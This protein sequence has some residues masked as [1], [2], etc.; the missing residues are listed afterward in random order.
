MYRSRAILAALILGV[1][2]LAVDV[3]L[4][5]NVPLQLDSDLDQAIKDM[6]KTLIHVQET[7]RQV[8]DAYMVL[9]QTQPIRET[10]PDP[11]SGHLIEL[12]NQLAHLGRSQESSFTRLKES[13]DSV[14]RQMLALGAALAAGQALGNVRWEDIESRG[15]IV[16]PIEEFRQLKLGTP[17]Y[18]VIDRMGLPKK[19][20]GNFFETLRVV[21]DNP[22]G[23]ERPEISLTFGG[24][25]LVAKYIAD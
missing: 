7:Q 4:R 22:D 13:I 20:I 12:L 15:R 17:Y 8:L 25:L 23:S 24:G 6:H 2:L 18:V 14:E 5:L 10:V 9:M 1:I 19:L 21:W 11:G 16:R 3:S